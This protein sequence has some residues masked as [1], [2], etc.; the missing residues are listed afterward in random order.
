MAAT[1]VKLLETELDDEA[2]RV[3]DPAKPPPGVPKKTDPA[4]DPIE[5]ARSKSERDVDE[6]VDHAIMEIG[7]ARDEL[8][9]LMNDLGAGRE[10][11]KDRIQKLAG[12]SAKAIRAKVIIANSLIELRNAEKQ[13]NGG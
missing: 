12:F 1:N 3:N 4:I 6:I 8:D 13:N 9:Q 10:D 7:K 2:A 5:A 11:V